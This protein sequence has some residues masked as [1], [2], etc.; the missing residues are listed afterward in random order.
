VIQLNYRHR[1]MRAAMTETLLQIAEVCDGV[2]CDMAMLVLP[3]VFA[4]TWGHASWPSDGSEPAD[5]PFWVEAVPRVKQARPDFVFMAEVYWD[6]E[7]D[8][9]QQGFDYTYDKRL[10]DRLRSREADAVRKHL[11]AD[12][13]FQRRSARFLENHDEPRAAGTFPWPVHQ[14]AA[15]AAFLV[16]GLRFFYEG[17]F[18]GRRVRPSMHLGRRPGEA[19]RAEVREFYGRLL[20][21]LKRPEVRDG[22]W[23]LRDCRPAWGDNATWN[24]FLASTWEGA[25]QRLLVAVNYGPSQGQCYVHLPADVRGRK[26]CLRDLLGP[27]HFDRDGD[28]LAQRRLR[29]AARLTP[30]SPLSPEGRGETG[31]GFFGKRMRSLPTHSSHVLS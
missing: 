3:D 4:N 13:E 12:P 5:V 26:F 18:E 2:R 30:L 14:A 1:G 6:R 15:V 27:A 17:Q 25:G 7:F 24:Q 20:E 16:P 11:W 8:L 19:P 23:Q 31:Y 21:V 28:D 9:Q 10:Y 22:R 29:G